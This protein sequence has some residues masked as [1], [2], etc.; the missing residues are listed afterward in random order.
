MDLNVGIF[1]FRPQRFQTSARNRQEQTN[2]FSYQSCEFP[3]NE[4]VYNET[5]PNEYRELSQNALQ[6]SSSQTRF[7]PVPNRQNRL[8][9]ATTTSANQ[10]FPSQFVPDSFQ[11]YPNSITT[12]SGCGQFPYAQYQQD[13]PLVNQRAQVQQ[14]SFQNSSVMHNQSVQSQSNTCFNNFAPSNNTVDQEFYHFPNNTQSPNR[15]VQFQPSQGPLDTGSYNETVVNDFRQLS[16]DTQSADHHCE[17][18]TSRCFLCESIYANQSSQPFPNTAA[19]TRRRVRNRT[20]RQILCV[21]VST[22]ECLIW[23]M[24]LSTDHFINQLESPECATKLRICLADL[25]GKP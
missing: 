5:V 22:S 9:C 11:N 20:T 16:H 12:A 2:H 6:Q 25:L 1:V 24:S 17:F 14:F 13:S 23:L 18:P 3:Y 8:N 10:R 15:S 21:S 7:V 19:F 4:L